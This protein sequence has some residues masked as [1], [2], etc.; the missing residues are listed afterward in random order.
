MDINKWKSVAVRKS[1]YDILKALCADKFRAPAAMISKLINDYVERLAKR[2]KTS[3][4]KYKERLL[5]V[6][7]KKR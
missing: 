6:G 3:I 7:S 5:N 4:E 2:D 1:D